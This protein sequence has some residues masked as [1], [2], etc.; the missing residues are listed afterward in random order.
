LRISDRP[1]FIRHRS[2]MPQGSMGLERTLSNTSTGT[3]RNG[4]GNNGGYPGDYGHAGED[5]HHNTGAGRNPESNGN[6]SINGRGQV[7]RPTEIGE[8]GNSIRRDR[9][10]RPGQSYASQGQSSPSPFRPAPPSTQTRPP[11]NLKSAMNA[12]NGYAEPPRRTE[13]PSGYGQGGHGEEMPWGGPFPS[14]HLWPLNETFAT[15]MI[16]LPPITGRN[17]AERVS[18]KVPLLY[19][20]SPSPH[21]CTM[22]GTLELGGRPGRRI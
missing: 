11:P 8:S 22:A 4:G 1:P 21:D 15:K 12:I 18:R 9:D 10:G 5:M 3:I 19:D 7:G 17:P 13:S 16:H 6:G 20:N 2:T 14:L